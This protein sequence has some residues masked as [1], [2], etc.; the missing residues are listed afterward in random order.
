MP[1]RN[2]RK[3]RQDRPKSKRPSRVGLLRR[4]ESHLAAGTKVRMPSG[5]DY[6][7]ATDGSFRRIG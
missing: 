4:L 7:V 2:R 5:R 1:H 3:E 6:V